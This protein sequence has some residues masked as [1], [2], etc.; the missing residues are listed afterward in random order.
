MPG[1]ISEGDLKAALAAGGS[2]AEVIVA[3]RRPPG[4][5]TF[6]V[7]YLRLRWPRAKGRPAGTPEW[8]FV[9]TWRNRSSGARSWRN[10][11]TLLD[12]LAEWGFAGRHT[13]CPE[14]DPLL[15]DIGAAGMPDTASPE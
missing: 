8:A 5:G 14:G 12:Q 10:Y 15:A 2:I 11:A 6:F 3:V 7:P 4:L 13:V 9:A 1:S